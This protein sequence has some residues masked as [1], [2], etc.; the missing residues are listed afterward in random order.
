MA[1]S[2]SEILLFLPHQN[3]FSDTASARGVIRN[4]AHA[5]G[6]I[7]PIFVGP[8]ASAAI[9]E[10]VSSEAGDVRTVT[11]KGRLATGAYSQ[12]DVVLNGTT[13]V[14]TAVAYL[15]ILSVEVS[16]T[17]ATRTVS[18][19][20]GSSDTVVVTIP[21]LY[22]QKR[23]LF[24]NAVSD[25][26]NPVSRYEL[27]YVENV[28]AQAAVGFGM[29][30]KTDASGKHAIGVAPASG[31]IAEVTTGEPRKSAPSSVT[32]VTD[33]SVVALPS[34]ASLNATS[35][36][37]YYIRQALSA[38]GAYLGVPITLTPSWSDAA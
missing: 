15:W 30:I 13:V 37:G 4:T 27:V 17:H 12:E 6:A 20:H 19:R 29:K 10:M 16:A 9:I 32:F 34:G 5:S 38:D 11:I 18:I 35:H 28:S 7:S 1:I 14:Q 25:P 22:K 21:P 24:P 23:C 36:W 33:N 3:P 31:D 26:S 8:L 2:N